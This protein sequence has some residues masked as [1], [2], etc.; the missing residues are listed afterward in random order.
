MMNPGLRRR[1]FPVALSLLLGSAA[2][3]ADSNPGVVRL[4]DPVVTSERYETFGTPLPE[5][6]ETINLATLLR[7]PERYLKR[8]IKVRTRV[9][10]VC[11]AKGCFFIAQEGTHAARVSFKDYSFFVPT[12]ISGRTV[13]L[14]GELITVELSQ[15]QAAHLSEDAGA[16]EVVSA[17][18]QYEIVANSVRVPR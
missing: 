11:Q 16:P 13:T 5:K 1:L 9:A 7:E 14:A 12:D 10:Q 4:S 6:G 15:A 17:G 3:V 2:T 8:S 18:V